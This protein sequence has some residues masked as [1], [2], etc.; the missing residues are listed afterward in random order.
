[1]LI[2]GINV[3]EI[4][5]TEAACVNFLHKLYDLGFKK[6]L[7]EYELVK[8]EMTCKEFVFDYEG[9]ST[10]DLSAILAGAIESIDRVNANS[11]NARYEYVGL[12]LDA[13]WYYNEKTRNIAQDEYDAILRKYA[14]MLT[15]EAVY[16]RTYTGENGADY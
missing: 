2:Y 3:S 1:M 15:N 4:H 11:D 6:P 9:E 16:I 13:P 10:T 8:D 12:A 7:D 14:D 5:P